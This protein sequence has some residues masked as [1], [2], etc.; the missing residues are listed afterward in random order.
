MNRGTP[1]TH[2]MTGAA[3]GIATHEAHSNVSNEHR[4]LTRL[5]PNSKKKIHIC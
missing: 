1:P 4:T 2:A 5:Q 3:F